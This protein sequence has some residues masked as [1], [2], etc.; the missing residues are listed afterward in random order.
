MPGESNPVKTNK[1]TLETAAYSDK[2]AA[3]AA[4][5]RAALDEQFACCDAIETKTSG[6]HQAS[7][8]IASAM[9]ATLYLV[10]MCYVPF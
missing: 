7:F 5:A 6:K 8:S 4:I 3:Q 10:F 9:T 1:S 2:D